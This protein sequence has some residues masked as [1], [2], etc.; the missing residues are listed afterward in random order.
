[1]IGPPGHRPATLPTV[2]EG[3]AMLWFVLYHL[4]TFILD[5]LATPRHADDKDVEVLLLRHQLRLL[6]RER[7]RPPRL[8]RCEKLTLAALAAK[9]RGVAAGPRAR[10]DR[11]S[12]S[13]SPRRC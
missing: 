1:M 13:S 10:L 5:L 7:P 11:P 8:S 3:T 4:I 9:L 6:Q 2:I 12:S